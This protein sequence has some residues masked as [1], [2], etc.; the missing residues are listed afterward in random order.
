MV[1]AFSGE[2]LSV[3]MD[4]NLGW[5][6]IGIDMVVTKVDGNSIVEE[7]DNEPAVNIYSKYLRVD[8]NQYFLYGANTIRSLSQIC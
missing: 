4:C 5:Q 1:V 6:P 8:P 3:Y 2:S 7:I